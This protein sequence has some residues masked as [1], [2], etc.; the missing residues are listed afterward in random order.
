LWDKGVGEFVEAARR[1]R[2]RFPE[3]KFQLLGFLNVQNPSAVP[4]SAVESWEAEG[5]VTYL[6]STDDV[7]PYYAD[8]DCV[9][10][11]SYREGTPRTLLEAASMGLPIITTDAVGCRETVDDGITGFLCKLKDPLDLA[12]KMERMLLM[13]PEKRGEMGIAGRAKMEREF[14]DR[15]VI[16]Q[17]LAVV[18]E[19]SDRVPR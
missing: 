19:I 17:Y 9:V 16:E 14:D 2:S 4:R 12:E 5:V 15:I 8:V 10:L 6:G 11:P 3:A 13:T 1:L 7:R 18:R